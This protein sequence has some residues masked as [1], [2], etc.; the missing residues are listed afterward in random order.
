MYY[1]Y[2]SD[3][4]L[5]FTSNQSLASVS[6][7]LDFSSLVYFDQADGSAQCIMSSVNLPSAKV[8]SLIQSNNLIFNNTFL[9]GLLTPNLQANFMSNNLV[10]SYVSNSQGDQQTDLF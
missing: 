8:N 4:N 7:N 2:K 9:L 1:V 6:S 10:F 5:R 3:S